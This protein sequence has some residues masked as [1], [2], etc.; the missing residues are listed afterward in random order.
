MHRNA[1]AGT[2]YNDAEVNPSVKEKQSKPWAK[3][4]QEGEAEYNAIND[5]YLRGEFS[6]PDIELDTLGTFS[7]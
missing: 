7:S 5:A 6:I 2:P 4:L 3:D 1:R